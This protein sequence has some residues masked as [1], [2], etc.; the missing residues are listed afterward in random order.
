MA[1]NCWNFRCCTA[2]RKQPKITKVSGSHMPDARNRTPALFRSWPARNTPN[3]TSHQPEPCKDNLSSHTS[4]FQQPY[5]SSWI[6]LLFG[7]RYLS[8]RCNSITG[9]FAADAPRVSGSSRSTWLRSTCAR[10]PASAQHLPYVAPPSGCAPASL[11]SQSESA[12]RRT[13]QFEAN[14]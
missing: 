4:S 11:S 3:N 14:A 1:Q 12:D 13:L 7:C 2:S 6:A 5:E 8:A 9:Y 10:S